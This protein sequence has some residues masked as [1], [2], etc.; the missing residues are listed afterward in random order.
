MSFQSILPPEAFSGDGEP[1]PYECCDCEYGHLEGRR[2]E[3]G[4]FVVARI[5]STDPAAYLDTR[6]APGAVVGNAS[7]SLK[8]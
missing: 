1:L 5:I 4:N 2:D 6:Y 8:Q 7:C 3:Q